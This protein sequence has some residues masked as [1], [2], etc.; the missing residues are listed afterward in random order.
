MKNAGYREL[1]VWQKAM[2]LC[3][4][5]YRVTADLPDSERFGLRSQLRRAAVSVPSN[6]AEGHSRMSTGDYRHHLQMARG[7]V[8]ELETQLLL[9]VQLGFLP[10]SQVES[11]LQLGNEISRM[12]STL[13]NKLR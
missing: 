8:A 11:A 2:V 1:I 4:V 5:V 3:E 12:T 7:S 10:E 6:I 9:C 13:I